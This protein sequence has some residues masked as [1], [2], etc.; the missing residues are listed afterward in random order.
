MQDET[1]LL[2]EFERARERAVALTDD[3]FARPANDP[4]REALWREVASE[5]E[6]ARLLLERW[7]RQPEPGAALTG[8]AQPR[9]LVPA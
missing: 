2:E 8:S 9:V 4:L 5:T 3:Y 1:A 6:R 7:L